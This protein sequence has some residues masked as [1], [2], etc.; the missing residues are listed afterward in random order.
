MKAAQPDDVRDRIINTYKDEIRM[1]ATRERDFQHLEALIAELQRKTKAVEVGMDHT[2]K[3]YEDKLNGQTKAINHH[4]EEIEALKKN[5]HDKQTENVHLQDQI[6][7]CKVDVEARCVEIYSTSK[8]LEN[9]RAHN[10]QIKREID[11]VQRDIYNGQDTLKKQNIIQSNLG[12]ELR[13]R[14]HEIE[15]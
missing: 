4:N 8:D 14:E 3:D 1:H 7:N 5:V 12:S 2:Q 6:G 9:T 11:L 13:Q 15:E 10:D